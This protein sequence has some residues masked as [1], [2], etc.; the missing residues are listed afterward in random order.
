[1]WKKYKS[2]P[3][4]YD[5]LWK[6]YKSFPQLYDN[7]WKKYKSFPQGDFYKP[8]QTLGIA[9]CLWKTIAYN[10]WKTH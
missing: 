10:L 1:M 2:F 8:L 5:N 4:L 9:N 3:Q 7:L 6:K